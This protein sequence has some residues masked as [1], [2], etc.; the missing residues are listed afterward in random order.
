MGVQLAAE[1]RFFYTFQQ[2]SSLITE[3]LMCSM[4]VKVTANRSALKQPVQ[5]SIKNVFSAFPQS[6]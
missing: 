3:R 4:K 2:V 1:S 5:K 6:Q